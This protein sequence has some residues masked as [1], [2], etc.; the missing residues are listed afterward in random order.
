MN[1]VLD[2]S[3]E[4]DVKNNTRVKVGKQ[5]DYLVAGYCAKVF[6]R[7]TFIEGR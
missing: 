3:E 7:S 4:V 2:D 1:L 5:A 6:V